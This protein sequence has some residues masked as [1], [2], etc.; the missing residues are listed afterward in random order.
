[1]P[2]TAPWSTKGVV[3]DANSGEKTLKKVYSTGPNGLV[4]AKR[5]ESGGATKMKKFENGRCSDKNG[6][7]RSKAEEN[8][9]DYEYQRLND[10]RGSLRVAGNLHDI[11]VK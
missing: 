6:D 3:V 5:Q 1:M 8:R 2:Q 9:S 4:A 7:H 10:R 11:V